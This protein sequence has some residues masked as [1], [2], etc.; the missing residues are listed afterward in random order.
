M[1]RKHSS[2]SLKELALQRIHHLFIEAENVCAAHPERSE[3]Y[4]VLARKIAMKAR[5]SLPR[6]LKRHFCR[7]CGA[8]LNTGATSRVRLRNQFVLVTCLHCKSQQKF[9][10]GKRLRKQTKKEPLSRSF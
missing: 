9:P 1:Q 7:H 4:V 5:I 10:Y 6:E 3:R 2:L 8:Y